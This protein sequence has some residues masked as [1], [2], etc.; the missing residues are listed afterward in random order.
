MTD[1]ISSAERLEAP[2]VSTGH[3]NPGAAVSNGANEVRVPPRTSRH[4]RPKPTVACVIPY[5]NGSKFIE[6]AV[7]S[8]LEQTVPPDEFVIVNDGSKDAEREFLHALAQK[9]SVK[10][11]DQVN[12]GQGSARNKG[13]A[14][15][16][17]DFICFLDQD[18]FYLPN[19]IEWL[20][21]ALPLDDRKLGFVYADL[22]VADAGG[23]II[24]SGVAK[25]HSRHPKTSLIDMIS[26]D[27]F[28]LPSAS[29]VSRKALEAVGGFD[30]QFMGYEDDDLFMRIFRKG[31]SNHYL[32][33]PVTVWCIH[34]ESTS[35]S[36]RMSR[37]RF[38]YFK[39]L[40]DMLP[41]DPERSLFF[42]RDCFVPRFNK[43]FVEEAAKAAREGGEHA[44]EI[45]QI[46]R[47]YTE[48]VMANPHVRGRKKLKLRAAS[49]LLP[50][51][52]KAGMKVLDSVYSL[53]VVRGLPRITTG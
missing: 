3:V 31:Y 30:P 10:V 46:L 13:V 23:N 53:P 5:Y 25:D 24:F 45:F 47:D 4:E 48:M 21:Q 2:S 27:M 15:T 38:R 1:R 8:V 14:S 42:F 12:G 50:R 29:I 40:V 35:Y 44:E 32:D 49:F 39:K 6:R 33:R 41:D 28:V 22:N 51:M 7:V 43:S 9:Y 52:S 36:V 16:K 20:A 19:H 26:T 11:V 17:A 34:K 37:S 18:D